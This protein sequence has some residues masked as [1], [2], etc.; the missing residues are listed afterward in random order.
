MGLYALASTLFI[1]SFSFPIIM[2]IGGRFL[3]LHHSSIHTALAMFLPLIALMPLIVGSIILQKQKRKIYLI[4]LI[5]FGITICWLANYFWESSFLQTS[6][7]DKKRIWFFIHG[8]LFPGLIGAIVSRKSIGLIQKFIPG[9]VIVTGISSLLYIMSYDFNLNFVRLLGEMGLSAGIM[10]SLGASACLSLLILQQNEK[11]TSSML[12]SFGMIFLILLHCFAI[13]ISGTRAAIVTFT[14]SLML[15][16]TLSN[17]KKVIILFLFIVMVIALFF[18]DFINYLVPQ[19]TINRLA[20]FYDYG[21]E[22]RLRLLNAITQIIYENPL[23]KVTGY[24]DSILGMAYS[25]NAIIQ[26]IAEAGIAS[27]PA[28]V[29]IC[30][31]GLKNAF[32]FRKVVH[33]RALIILSGN[34]F[35]QSFSSGGAYNSLLWFLLFFFASLQC[36]RNSSYSHD[37]GRSEHR[38]KESYYQYLKV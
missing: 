17:R 2:L 27:I 12:V 6:G 11:T 5:I 15:Y 13:I 9:I 38:S 18:Y 32:A 28:L 20:T 22:I 3:G 8:F 14:I 19:A 33:I 35:I 30:I 31:I 37:F 26:L 29:A 24:E 23:G 1:L 25:H 4:I 7:F 21:I 10:A 34:V 36:Q 16:F